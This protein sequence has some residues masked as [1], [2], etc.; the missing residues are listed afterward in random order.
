MIALCGRSKPQSRKKNVVN[1]RRAMSLKHTTSILNQYYPAN[2]SP[3]VVRSSFWPEAF[4]HACFGPEMEQLLATP[5]K[6]GPT[7]YPSSS[8]RG[9]FLPHPLNHNSLELKIDHRVVHASITKNL[10]PLRCH[11]AQCPLCIDDTLKTLLE[12][13]FIYSRPAKMMDHVEKNY[14]FRTSP[15]E[16]MLCCYPICQEFYLSLNDLQHF[17]NHVRKVHGIVLRA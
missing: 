11:P 2:G 17:K 9:A 15:S 10:F 1:T 12:R 16:R 8:W 6:N 4:D 3:T 5:A 14:L 7:A 13:I